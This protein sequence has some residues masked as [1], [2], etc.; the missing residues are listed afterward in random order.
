M[1]Y[2]VKAFAPTDSPVP[3]DTLRIWHADK[4]QCWSVSEPGDAHRPE[5]EM[6]WPPA[7]EFWDGISWRPWAERAGWLANHP[8]EGAPPCC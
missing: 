5:A 7:A 6:L 3:P 1:T 4:R 2:W 8:R